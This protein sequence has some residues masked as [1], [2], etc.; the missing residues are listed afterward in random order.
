MAHVAADRHI[1]TL[2]VALAIADG[3]EIQ[4]ALRRMRMVAVAGVD[5][6]RARARAR[7]SAPACRFL[8]AHDERVGVHRFERRQCVFEAF[9][10]A[11]RRARDIEVD[12]VGAEPLRGELEARTCARRRLEKEIHDRATGQQRRQ[13]AA[14]IGFAQ[15]GRAIEQRDD[16]FAAEPVQRQQMTS[17]LIAVRGADFFWP[18]AA[19]MRARSL[20]RTSFRG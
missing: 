3:Q 2:D 16:A 11:R 13:R 20:L 7:R 5:D 15:R 1:E 8:V 14:A 19:F 12:D 6:D 4:Q 18:D 9:A 10:L 17:R